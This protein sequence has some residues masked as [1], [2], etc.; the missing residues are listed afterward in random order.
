MV[1]DRQRIS[2][3]DKG[4]TRRTLA[5]KL[6][7]PS[8]VV[9]HLPRVRLSTELARMV[10]FRLALVSA[11]AG[12]G[13]TT[14]LSEWY[15]ALRK[16][17]VA[18]A[19][20]S[21]DDFDNE[22]RRFL[23]HLV[24]AIQ[25]T[26][27]DFG[28]DALEF[29]T[30]NPDVLIADVA[31][32]LVHDFGRLDSR[33][34]VFL[35][36]YH[37]IRN[38][39]IHAVVD[40]LLRYVPANVQVVIGTRRDPPLSIERLRVQGKVL[41]LRWEDLRFNVD[42]AR[43][44]L[45]DACSLPLSESQVRALC[46]RTE[47]WV[48][49]L[50][51]AAM[52]LTDAA[53]VD[54]LLS[55]FTGV[56]RTI[57]DYLLECVF[58]RQSAN[59]RNFLMDTAILDRMTAPLC[60]ALTGR[61]GSQQLIETLEKKNLF[62]FRLNDQGTWHRYHHL[63]ADFLRNRLLARHP[64]KVAVLYDRASEWFETKGDATEAL[65]LAIAGSRFRRAARLL[66]TTGRELFRRGD[67]KELRRWIEALPDRTIRRSPILCTLHAWSLGYLGD[68]DDARQR[69]SCAEAALRQPVTS[70]G[71]DRSPGAA[72]LDAELQVLRT[73]LSI[74]QTD[75]PDASGLTSLNPEIV[76]LIPRE[77]ATLRGFASIALGYA[78]RTAG[79][80]ALAL[81]HFKEA[82]EV[83][84]RANSSL[85]DLTARLNI[86]IVNYL[87]GHAKNA[88]ESFRTSIEVAGERRWLRTI[89][90][91]F[92]RYG[93]ALVLQEK[94]RLGAALEE[95][96]EAIAF[97]EASE[98]YGFLGVALVERARVKL[99]LG[100]TDLAATDLAQARQIAREHNV[101]RVSF[102]ADLLESRMAV[103]ASDSKKAVEFLKAA[104]AAFAGQNVTDRT[105]F[106]EKY[107]FFLMERLFVLIAQRQFGE[108]VRLAGKALRSARVAGRGRNVIEF[109]VLQA[110]AWN[111]LGNTNR[112]LAKLEQALFLADRDGIVRPFV[113]VGKEIVPLLRQL[114][115]K[116]RLRGALTGILSALGDSGD[117]VSRQTAPGAHKESFHHREVQI[118]ELVSQGLR[119]REIGKRL[120]LSETTVK[121]YLKRLYC[122][123]YVST[124]TEA[125]ARARKLGLIV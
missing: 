121:W 76:S 116:E 14:V 78:S 103:Q 10:A 34:V 77:E 56:Q 125:I 95:L 16:L 39:T 25:A 83:S 97:L 74:I 105:I 13:K 73:I 43:D 79:N 35:D 88:E 20:L 111:G 51:L 109:L 122:K 110:S 52:T 90:A 27:V 60:D 61:R 100:R 66:E 108:A 18:A 58:S 75:E 29:L 69:I 17:H 82:L 80:L 19:W 85:V 84:E 119:N 63:F 67:F 6:R 99:A 107:E 91:A 70:A 46:D 64:E 112:A 59:V 31:T 42:E 45:K 11:P 47:G 124:R 36:D 22:P 71:H 114:K 48:T 33:V 86:G 41:E 15:S 12:S 30:E 102:R 24:S 98:A 104:E 38:R 21:L 113:G 68:F 23:A 101:K 87:M 8:K 62:I 72:L 50:Q 94:N 89:G 117:P 5:T 3:L 118:L 54:R 81:R 1:V 28:R 96:S 4:H 92:L 106:S 123:L 49:G 65:R 44:Y 115:G 7:P 37:E 120:F 93:L 53:E 40:F 55:C 32:A 2:N 57:A 9:H 26:R